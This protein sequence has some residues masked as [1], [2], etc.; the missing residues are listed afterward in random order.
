M[1]S[2]PA[3]AVWLYGIQIG[4]LSEPTYGKLRLDYAPEAE[5][6]FG[7]GSSILSTSMP[8]DAQRRP[9][10]DTVRGYFDALLP[11]AEAKVHIEPRFGVRS[12]DDFGL[13][14]A[15]G[16]DCAGAVVL[17]GLDDDPPGAG[18]SI[19]PLADGE[20][21]SLVRSLPDRPLGA[22]DDMRVS[23]AGAQE[24]L[25]LTKTPDGRWARP[26]GG[27]PSTHILKPQ[28]M[29]L[30]GYATGEAFC[31][32]LAKD[33]GLTTVDAYVLDVA[34][35]P[36]IAVTRYDRKETADGVVR[37]HQEDACQAL[38]VDTTSQPARKYQAYGGPSLRRFADLVASHQPADRRKLLAI[39]ALNVVVGN[40]DAHARNLSVL[41]PADGSVC[42]AP[43][44]DITPTAF[45]KNVPTSDGPKDMTDRLGMFINDKRSIHEVTA[46]DLVAEGSSWG[47]PESEANEVVHRTLGVLA[48]LIG[49]LGAAAGLPGEMP[50]WMARRCASLATGVR[51]DAQVSPGASSG[52]P[53]PEPR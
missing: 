8:L 33:L 40:A 50:D 44:Y 21:E 11:E 47:M 46:A 7:L 14:S 39:T 20:L 26:L 1:A 51:A 23:L 3:L 12:G 37:I 32:R 53:R 5:E 27:R 10:G 4:V 19:E 41:H 16:R 43:A 6:R 52:S 49:R 45:Y 13:L 29:R 30:D 24:K 22:D 34:G 36:T 9:R 2:R 17:Q 48:D 15:I 35:R 28:D 18:G 42:L 25:L 31:L 38:A